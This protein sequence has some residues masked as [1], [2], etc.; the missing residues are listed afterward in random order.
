MYVRTATLSEPIALIV[1]EHP[2][3]GLH[4]PC[5]NQL[6]LLTDPV[7]MTNRDSRKIPQL[8]GGLPGREPGASGG[9]GEPTGSRTPL[10]IVSTP[11]SVKLQRFCKK[12]GVMLDLSHSV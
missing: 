7:L 11:G 12:Q 2:F 5:L 9:L 4:E 8:I 1:V 6:I 10:R 3:N